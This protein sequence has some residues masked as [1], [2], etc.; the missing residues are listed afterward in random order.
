MSLVPY[1]LRPRAVIRKAAVKRGVEGGSVV[2]RAL[3]MY[4]VGGPVLLRT[5]AIRRGI[6]GGN[7]SWQLIG[8]ILLVSQDARGIFGKQSEPLGKWK[9]G[10]GQFVR[11][12]NTKPL[13]KKDRKRLGIT[14]ATVIAEAVASAQAKHPDRKIVVKTK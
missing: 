2:W 10:P 12:T 13:S 11:V 6:F 14:R 9:V 4:F 5:Q 7:R 1:A 3:A 8:L